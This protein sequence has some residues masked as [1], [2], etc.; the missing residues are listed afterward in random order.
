M[1][2]NGWGKSYK[3]LITGENY[4]KLNFN[5]LCNVL[6]EHNFQRKS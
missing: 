1:G 3:M 5:L 4:M 6:L 2:L